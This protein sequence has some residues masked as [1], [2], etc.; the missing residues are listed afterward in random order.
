MK[1]KAIKCEFF[2]SQM[3][4]LGHVLSE[5]DIQADPART[6]QF[7][8]IYNQVRQSLCFTG[9]YRQ[10]MK[11]LAKIA[12]PLNGQLVGHYTN[13]QSRKKLKGIKKPVFF[14]D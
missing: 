1:L 3:C 2:K 14:I 10:F 13:T 7:L 12:G 6:G 4:Y 11:G 8:K 9:Y 5:E